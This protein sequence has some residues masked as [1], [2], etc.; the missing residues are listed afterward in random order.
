MISLKYIDNII[1]KY[2]IILQ[3]YS[4]YDFLNRESIR[5]TKDPIE[6]ILSDGFYAIFHE[7][8]LQNFPERQILVL[9]GSQFRKYKSEE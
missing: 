5:A 7:R 2:N 3:I 8:W 1:Y 4:N 9:D 6:I